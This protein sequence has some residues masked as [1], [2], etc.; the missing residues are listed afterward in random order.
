MTATKANHTLQS[1]LLADRMRRFFFSQASIREALENGTPKQ[2]EF[3]Q[4]T[5]ASELERRDVSRI[6][7]M[8][9]HA[10]FPTIKH[11][12]DYD[13][14]HVKFPTLMGREDVL[15]LEFI[16]QKRTLI[17]YGICGSGKTMLAIAL[18]IL[19]CNQGYKVKFMTMTHLI[20]KLAKPR[21]EAMLERTLLDLKKLDLL[22]IDE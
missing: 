18:G 5:L 8:V 9:K 11:I 3:L 1:A 22:I 17:F 20:A 10:G 12:G 14:S 21:S 16:T 19:A 4:R 13:F 6:A 2:L 7:R 15:S